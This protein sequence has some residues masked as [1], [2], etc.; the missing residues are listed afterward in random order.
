MPDRSKAAL[1]IRQKAC[2]PLGEGLRRAA[3]YTYA[4]WVRSPR[5]AVVLAAFA[6]LP[7]GGALERVLTAVAAWLVVVTLLTVA[8]AVIWSRPRPGRVL[9]TVDA[10]R[11][12][13]GVET[14][15]ETHG[16]DS[17]LKVGGLYAVPRRRG[18]GRGVT[19]ALLEEADRCGE[20]LAL[21]VLPG[22]LRAK[23]EHEG[24]RAVPSQRW[25]GRTLVPLLARKPKT[26][27]RVD[28]NALGDSASAA[29]P[30]TAD[31]PHARHE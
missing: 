24:F 8:V 25:P 30:V 12:C 4:F 31:E 22:A 23:Y 5:A 6:A 3:C 18:I 27:A 17:W 21:H 16:Q 14:N 26:T 29:S 20:Q 1:Q 28:P 7:A 15:R 10:G 13:G 9:W 2:L 11:S 19:T